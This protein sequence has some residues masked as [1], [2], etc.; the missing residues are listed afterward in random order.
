MSE[1]E[2]GRAVTRYLN[3]LSK[4]SQRAMRRCL[5]ALAEAGRLGPPETAKW[6]TLSTRKVAGIV[7][8]LQERLSGASVGKHLSALRG[9]LRE[10]QALGLLREMPEIPLVDPSPGSPAQAVSVE[11]VGKLLRACRE[12]AGGP[13]GARDAALI[14]LLYGAGL[15]R[16]EVVALDLADYTGEIIRA[17]DREI[18]L[19]VGA[20]EAVDAWTAVRSRAP[21]PLLCPVLDQPVGIR[22]MSTQ[23]VLTALSRRSKDAGLARAIRPND[24]RRAYIEQML[25]RTDVKTVQRLVGHS[26]PV[27]TARYSGARP[28]VAKAP[29]PVAVPYKA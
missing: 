29:K 6:E 24:L 14:S 7:S 19:A 28:G 13:S 9:V 16:A 18:P 2:M 26:Y 3:R 15:R 5:Q 17:G 27:T 1:E 21:G 10:S 20:R 22:R 23:A 12:G 11:E 25:Q 8:R 4:P